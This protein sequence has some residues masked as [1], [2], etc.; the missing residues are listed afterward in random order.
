MQLAIMPVGSHKLYSS[1]IHYTLLWGQTTG[2]QRL[3]CQC[4]VVVVVVVIVVVVV[5]RRRRHSSS[6]TSLGVAECLCI[7]VM[8]C[9]E[10]T[11]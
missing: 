6:N 8:L 4:I 5:G 10:S 7:T 3:Q 1:Q 9:R 11:S 2:S